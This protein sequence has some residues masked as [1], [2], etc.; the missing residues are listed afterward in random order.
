[1]ILVYSGTKVNI[2]KGTTGFELSKK[3]W[4]YCKTIFIPD[5]GTKYMPEDDDRAMPDDD[6]DPPDEDVTVP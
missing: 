6:A 5:L 1:M 3:T 2:L 4:H